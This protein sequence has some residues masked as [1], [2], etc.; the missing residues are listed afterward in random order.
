MRAVLQQVKFQTKTIGYNYITC[1]IATS[2]VLGV[3]SVFR[4]EKEIEPFK[5]DLSV[6]F[7]DELVSSKA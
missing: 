4:R 6:I 7:I 2:K 1:C 3:P 5:R